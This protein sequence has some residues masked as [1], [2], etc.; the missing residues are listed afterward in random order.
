MVDGA[1]SIE[2]NSDNSPVSILVV[3]GALMDDDG[4]CLM[5]QRPLSKHHGG[6]WEFPGGKVEAAETPVESLVRELRE[7]LGITIRPP[8]CIPVAFAEE[9]RQS[10][11]RAIVIL[12]YRIAS[13]AGEPAALEGEAIGWFTPGEVAELAKPPLD[14]MLADSLFAKE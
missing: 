4:R 8:D 5:H 6:L 3:A 2:K 13:W 10:G 7:E 14:C 12:L 11:Q 1:A 9:G